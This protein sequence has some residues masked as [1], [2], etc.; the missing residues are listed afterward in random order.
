MKDNVKKELTAISAA[1]ILVFLS[2]A[3]ACAF[4][5]FCYGIHL[6]YETSPVILGAIAFVAAIG[7]LY[8]CIRVDMN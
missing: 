3:T 4:V 1:S 6:L 5:G 2:C 7:F 8:F